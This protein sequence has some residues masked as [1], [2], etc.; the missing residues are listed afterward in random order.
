M[1]QN[2][3]VQIPKVKRSKL[4]K[5]F[6]SVDLRCGDIGLWVVSRAVECVVLKAAPGACWVTAMAPPMKLRDLIKYAPAPDHARPIVVLGVKLSAANALSRHFS[7]KHVLCLECV[8]TPR[9][10]RELSKG[11]LVATAS[12]L[13]SRP[14]MARW[15]PF[16]CDGIRPC[17]Q[18]FT[19]AIGQCPQS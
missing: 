1:G 8:C 4:P 18:C 15:L 10:C 19:P 16:L 6:E 13:P 5:K 12:P 11:V 2:V 7:R 14:L 9:R 17:F 3:F